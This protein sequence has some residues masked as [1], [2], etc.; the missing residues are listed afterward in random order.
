M[1]LT[2]DGFC[3]LGLEP[4][5]GVA[6][7]YKEGGNQGHRHLALQ[8]KPSPIFSH[9]SIMRHVTMAQLHKRKP[10]L[11]TGYYGLTVCLQQSWLKLE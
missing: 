10:Y 8:Q 3:C 2:R 6:E 5:T 11:M 4:E 1:V 7:N 9:V